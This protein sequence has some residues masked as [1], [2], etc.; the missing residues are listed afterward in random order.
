MYRRRVFSA[1]VLIAVLSYG[2][3]APAD[4]DCDIHKLDQCSSDLFVFSTKNTI[5]ESE[6]DLG[7]FCKAQMEA[8]ECSRAYLKKC[9]SSVAQGVGSIFIDDIKEEITE[10]CDTSTDYHKE[11]I[12]HAPCLNK[13]GSGFQ[14]CM[15]SLT[16][17]LDI[18]SRLPGRFR[19]GGACCK[20][21][22][23]ESCVK[24]AVES[25]CSEDAV[26]FT[27]KVLQR[28][29]GELLGTV[30]VGYRS[31]DKCENIPYDDKPGDDSLRS[32]LTPLV[33]VGDALG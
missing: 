22:K 26:E 17:D 7:A 32:L 31:A 30:C 10:R 4:G 21:N 23:F 2:S 1:I 27:S 15:K 5:P 3:A 19:I 20:Y 11:Y 12:S 6:A 8:E 25:G 16:A 24:T 13:V 28:Y 18:A 29:A 14:T 33:K 9:T